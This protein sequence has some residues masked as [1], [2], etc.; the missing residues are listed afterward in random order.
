MGRKEVQGLHLMISST[1]GYIL[2][3]MEVIIK[4]GR[5]RRN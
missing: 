1:S 2:P 3:V 4:Y 5:V